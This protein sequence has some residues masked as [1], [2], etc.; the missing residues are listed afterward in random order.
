MTYSHNIDPK[1]PV[2]VYE[3]SGGICKDPSCDSQH[4]RDMRMSGA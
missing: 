3:S 4:F 1:N 2:C